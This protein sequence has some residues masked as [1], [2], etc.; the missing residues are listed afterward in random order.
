MG[1]F[2][3][4]GD[5]GCAQCSPVTCM[6]SPLDEGVAA[7]PGTAAS[8]GFMQIIQAGLR[9]AETPTKLHC[10]LWKRVPGWHWRAAKGPKTFYHVCRGC[11]IRAATRPSPMCALGLT[12]HGR[13]CPSHSHAA[14]TAC[15][16]QV[17]AQCRHC[18]ACIVTGCQ[19]ARL[20]RPLLA[21]P[22]PP[23]SAR[24]LPCLAISMACAQASEPCESTRPTAPV[25]V[26]PQ[27][28]PHWRSGR[29]R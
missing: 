5:S 24:S 20:L 17:P 7:K 14:C 3:H 27:A 18:A 11:S 28:T 22:A 16:P 23:L 9:L 25:V 2:R 6:S 26:P 1:I 13:L 8:S 29:C 12:R 15:P 10:C 4:P 21:Q 19:A